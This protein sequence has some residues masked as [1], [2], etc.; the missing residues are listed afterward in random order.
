LTTCPD[1][2][3]CAAVNGDALLMAGYLCHPCLPNMCGLQACENIPGRGFSCGEDNSA[4][5]V[6]VCVGACGGA[7]FGAC[8]FEATGCLE[9]CESDCQRHCVP[10]PEPA[11][12][13]EPEPE[14]ACV[15][16]KSCPAEPKCWLKKHRNRCPC[17]CRCEEGPNCPAKPDCT[18]AK[19]VKKCPCACGLH[20]KPARQ[21]GELDVVH[22]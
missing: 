18:R 4:A 9:A 22:I 17:A 3:D 10:E 2:E 12:E 7:C 13:P 8:Y 14:P 15:E 1:R 11:P 16:G 21:L 6:D 19:H 5:T 20:L